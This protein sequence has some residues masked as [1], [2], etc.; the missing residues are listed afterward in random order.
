MADQD[1]DGKME[2][3]VGK[4]LRQNIEEPREAWLK[5][6]SEPKGQVAVWVII[7]IMVVSFIVYTIT[8]G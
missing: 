3:R 2:S 8:G 6:L 4:R 5:W 7:G 1:D